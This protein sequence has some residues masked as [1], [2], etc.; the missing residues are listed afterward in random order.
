MRATC[1]AHFTLDQIRSGVDNIYR[2]P[3]GKTLHPECRVCC[4]G[5]SVSAYVCHLQV[6]FLVIIL[7][8]I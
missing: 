5:R 4:V 2:I 3:V 1:P 6:L 7:P 8:C